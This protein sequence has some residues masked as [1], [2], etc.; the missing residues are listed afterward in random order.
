MLAPGSGKAA[1]ARQAGCEHPAH[2]DDGAGFQQRETPGR[3]VRPAAK[4]RGCCSRSSLKRVEG[5]ALGLSEGKS[6]NSTGTRRD[7]KPEFKSFPV[8]SR[9]EESSSRR[10]SSVSL[11]GH[12]PS[13]FSSPPGNRLAE[14]SAPGH[15]DQPFCWPAGHPPA[16]SHG[17][18]GW[19]GPVLALAKGRFFSS[20]YDTPVCNSF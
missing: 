7:A 9:G 14:P 13:R 8:L 6:Q 4:G 11:P 3:A 12:S 18:M 19:P 1:E 17:C 16:L 10:G 2:A 20:F 5:S 15:E